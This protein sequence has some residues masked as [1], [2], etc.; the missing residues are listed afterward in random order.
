MQK[1]KAKLFYSYSHQD[2]KFREILESHLAV[3]RRAGIIDEWHDRKISPG[4]NWKEDIDE[5]LINSDI[6][7]LLVSSN[8][9]ASNYCN[10]VET[11][12]ALDLHAKEELT[13]IPV[14]IR[15]CYWQVAR[16]AQDFKLQALPKDGIAISSFNNPDEAWLQ[17]VRGIH[18]VADIINEKKK[19]KPKIESF[20]N[21][22]NSIDAEKIVKSFL[23]TYSRWYFSP[24]RILKWGGNRQGFE[25][26]K[27]LSSTDISEILKILEKENIV[28]SIL[29]Q[30][31]NPIYKLK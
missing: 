18:K 17:V 4:S 11:A 29:S 27:A 14:I 8:F 15:P 7:I 26:L 1:I 13:V 2:E 16:F 25:D 21:S 5:N 9:L 31:G 22:K 24:L 20:K 23:R 19:L 28:K 30:R 3:L 10:D 6:V 12:I